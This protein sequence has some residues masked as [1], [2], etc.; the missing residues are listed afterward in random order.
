MCKMAKL[1]PRFKNEFGFVDRPRAPPP[2]LEGASRIVLCGC[3]LIRAIKGRGFG[4][5]WA[6]ERRRTAAR[7]G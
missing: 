7:V 2:G 6:G 5:Y 1:Q 4:K 3:D